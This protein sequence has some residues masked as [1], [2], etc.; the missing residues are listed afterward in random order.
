MRGFRLRPETQRSINRGF[1]AIDALRTDKITPA[2]ANKIAKEVRRSL[3]E[4]ASCA[5][6]GA[7]ARRP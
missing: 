6:R 4:R 7:Q 5:E 3:N 2:E 1:D